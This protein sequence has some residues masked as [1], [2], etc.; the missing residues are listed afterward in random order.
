MDIQIITGDIAEQQTDA[1]V[2]AWNCN[3]IPWF[4]LLPQGV[5]R[6]IRRSAGYKPFLELLLK[7]PM[8]T[9]SAVATSPGRMNCKCLIH[10]AGINPFWISTRKSIS[11]SV[12]NAV[13]LAVRNGCKSISF[14]VIGSGTGGKK[15]KKP[16]I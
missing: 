12:K 7:G 16:S 10:V 4:L 11:R 14:P 3:F 8:K 9:G 6:A 2:N 13:A 5:S 15:K 1:I